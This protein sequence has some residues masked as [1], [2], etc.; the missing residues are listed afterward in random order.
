MRVYALRNTRVVLG[1]GPSAVARP[2]S[3]EVELLPVLE[4]VAQVHDVGVVGLAQDRPLQLGAL[5]VATLDDLG[6]VDHL[7]AHHNV[8]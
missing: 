1:L 5:H 7:C 2:T 4:G 6:L 8:R 3:D